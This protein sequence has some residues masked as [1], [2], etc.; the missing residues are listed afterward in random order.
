MENNCVSEIL[1]VWHFSTVFCQ[2]LSVGLEFKLLTIH[3]LKTYEDQGKGPYCFIH[4]YAF[5]N[6]VESPFVVDDSPFM[7]LWYSDLNFRSALGFS[8]SVT[9]M[10]QFI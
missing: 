5:K 10:S 6:F 9:H 2:T 7:G 1:S 4:I 3:G 8:T